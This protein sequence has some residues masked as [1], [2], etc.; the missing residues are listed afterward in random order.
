MF[1]IINGKSFEYHHHEEVVRDLVCKTAPHFP[2]Q[3]ADAIRENLK[4]IL[5]VIVEGLNYEEEKERDKKRKQKIKR[6]IKRL[7]NF[8][9]FSKYKKTQRSLMTSAYDLILALEGFGLL[10]GFGLTNSFGDHIVGNP[11]RKSLLSFPTLRGG[12]H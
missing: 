4:N 3:S 2:Y 12:S 11:E 10:H 5:E 1:V 9:E 8:L 7:S 6:M